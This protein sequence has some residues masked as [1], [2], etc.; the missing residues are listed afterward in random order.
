MSDIKIGAD[1]RYFGLE[2]DCMGCSKMQPTPLQILDATSVEGEDLLYT[3]P[4]PA[5]SG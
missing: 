4:R 3:R 1:L 5:S 2:H